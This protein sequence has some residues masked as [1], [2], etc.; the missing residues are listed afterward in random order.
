M[1]GGWVGLCCVPVCV[2]VKRAY[3]FHDVQVVFVCFV[4]M[5]KCVCIPWRSRESHLCVRAPVW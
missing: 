5:C 3:S 2:C 4:E 1:D